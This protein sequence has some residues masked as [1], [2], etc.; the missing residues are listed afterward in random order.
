[1]VYLN[2]VD[3]VKK[4]IKETH[5]TKDRTS[6]RFWIGY[7]RALVDAKIIGEKEEQELY[8]FLDSITN[9]IIEND[10]FRDKLVDKVE[11][12]IYERNLLTKEEYEKLKQDLMKEYEIEYSS[13]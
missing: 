8:E 5:S 7:V 6:R 10:S 3:Y 2:W 12:R 11:S 9:N 1:M 13:D 4:Q